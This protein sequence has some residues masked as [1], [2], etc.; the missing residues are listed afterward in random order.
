[1]HVDSSPEQEPDTNQPDLMDADTQ[2]ISQHH[3]ADPPEQ[4]LQ[5]HD[6]QASRVPMQDAAE[7]SAD[8][9]P[10]HQPPQSRRVVKGR[11]RGQ[12]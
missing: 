11:R 8:A 4:R 1:M 7:P 6:H 12:A 9:Q 10:S 2:L 3:S 5:E